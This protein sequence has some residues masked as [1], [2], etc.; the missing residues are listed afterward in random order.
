MSSDQGEIAFIPVLRNLRYSFGGNLSNPKRVL[1]ALHGY[2]QLSNYFI[3]KFKDLPDDILMV[4]P[5]GPHRFYLLGSSGRVG[6]SWMTKEARDVDIQDN[7]IYLDALFESIVE[8]YPTVQTSIL[9]GF[10]QGG[11]TAARWQANGKKKHEALILWASVFPPDLSEFDS[12]SAKYSFFVLGDEDE[13]YPKA[14]SE[15][16]LSDY[17]KREFELV[18]YSGKHD[19]NSEVLNQILSQLSNIT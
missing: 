9:L 6:A 19:I 5:E 4:V 18:R 3:R 11:A 7:V 17:A 14:D 8:A 1:F 15:E 16:I 10:S 13:Y 12:F 2:G